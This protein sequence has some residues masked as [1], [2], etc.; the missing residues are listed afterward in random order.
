VK[1]QFQPLPAPSFTGLIAERGRVAEEAQG[2]AAGF[3]G[4]H[5]G[6]DVFGDLLVEVE[7]EF[8]L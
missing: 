5:S 7:L 1:K 8:V 2:G 4:A 3:F 6:G